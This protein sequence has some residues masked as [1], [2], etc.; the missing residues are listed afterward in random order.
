MQAQNG[1][2]VFYRQ[3]STERLGTNLI[4]LEKIDSTNDYI[5]SRLAELPVGSAVLAHEQ[6][7]G[8]GRSGR[9]WISPMGGLYFSLIVEACVC[10]P[11]LPL[12]AGLAVQCA[13][14]RV[15]GL[16]VQLKWPNDILA[17]SGGKLGGILCERRGERTICGIG[18]NIR[19]RDEIYDWPC[20]EAAGASPSPYLLAAEI[21][22]A[23]EPLLP[24]LP[25]F[26]VE[27]YNCC[28]ITLGQAVETEAGLSGI[29]RRVMP[30]GALAIETTHCTIMVHAGDVHLKKLNK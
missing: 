15:A 3:L 26:V 16:A 25:Q 12:A 13:I 6:L 20:L 18:I 14:E 7:A 8:R 17:V 10:A 2:A 11:V 22:N 30:D 28:C 4:E 23:L 21:C 1:L 5:K 29:A 19:A 24:E 9:L 27:K